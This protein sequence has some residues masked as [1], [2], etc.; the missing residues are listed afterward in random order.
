MY[1]VIK[2]MAHNRREPMDSNAGISALKLFLL[3]SKTLQT[4]HRESLK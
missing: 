3:T 1:N 2:T 4:Y